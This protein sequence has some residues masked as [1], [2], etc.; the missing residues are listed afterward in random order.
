MITCWITQADFCAS[1]NVIVKAVSLAAAN[2]FPFFFP[3]KVLIH[4][5]SLA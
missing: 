5:R 2:A 3:Q 4:S 1:T